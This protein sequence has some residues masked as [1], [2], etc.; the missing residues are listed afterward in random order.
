MSSAYLHMNAK[1]AARVAR[2]LALILVWWI[3]LMSCC[4]LRSCHGANSQL[5]PGE[6]GGVSSAVLVGVTLAF[7]SKPVATSGSSA[8]L[9]GGVGRVSSMSALVLV[10]LCV[11]CSML[12]S[13]AF[14]AA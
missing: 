1:A 4:A 11:K 6:P 8:A 13:G 9:L 7:A 12:T 2:S 10:S 3:S 5:M 14:M